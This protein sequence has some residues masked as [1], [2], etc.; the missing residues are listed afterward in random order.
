MKCSPCGWQDRHRQS[1][2][3]KS[4]CAPTYG[5]QLGLNP[6]VREADPKKMPEMKPN[7]SLVRSGAMD[8]LE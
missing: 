4:A 1:G 5:E 6:P 8:E 7:E 3:F 2:R